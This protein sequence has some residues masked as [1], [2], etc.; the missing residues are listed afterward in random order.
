MVEVARERLPAS[1]EHLLEGRIEE[2]PFPDASFDLVT[3]TGVLEYADVDAALAELA[4]VLR[5]GGR[6]VV[7]YPNPHAVYG[8]W[9]SRGW[10]PGRAHGQADRRPARADAAQ[11]GAGAL[12]EDAFSA[13]LRRAGLAPVRVA[14]TSFLLLPGPTA[15]PG[16]PRG[17]RT[18]GARGR[19]GAAP[20]RGGSR[21]RSS[22]T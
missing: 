6:G 17:R 13:R 1:A 4:R 12:D 21:R 10:Y 16:A 11:R 2:L 7:S 22:T 20:P 3:A 15:R 18:A 9:K 8:I 19:S 14:Y 5:P